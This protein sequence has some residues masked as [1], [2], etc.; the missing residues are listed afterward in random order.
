MNGFV[1]MVAGPGLPQSL[2]PDPG[3]ETTRNLPSSPSPG[4]YIAVLFFL[5]FCPVFFRRHARD[6][7]ES[8]AK[9]RRVLVADLIGKPRNG[10]RSV[11]G[12]QD[13]PGAS[14]PMISQV[15]RGRSAR[16][17]TELHGEIILINT[18]LA[19]EMMD[20]QTEIKQMSVQIVKRT[21]DIRRPAITATDQADPAIMLL[22][23][24]NDMPLSR[25]CRLHHS[26]LHQVYVT[27]SCI[28]FMAAGKPYTTN[29]VMAPTALKHF[30]NRTRAIEI[31]TKNLVFVPEKR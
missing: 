21:G 30:L 12:L 4:L 20:V 17:I 28:P 3:P 13:G 6:F 25:N 19:S 23:G 5:Q 29:T 7:F 16:E 10:Y 8:H 9:G 14:D 27:F 11:Q 31:L 26:K 2:K 22:D 24:I 15:F 1:W 18:A